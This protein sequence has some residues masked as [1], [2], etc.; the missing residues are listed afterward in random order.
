MLGG[1]LPAWNTSLEVGSTL[2]TVLAPTNLIARDELHQLFNP[3]QIEP[4]FLEKSP[5]TLEPDDVI[6]RIVSV[7][8]PS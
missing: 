1:R 5:Q 8:V 2:A 7:F 3:L 6:G 4:L